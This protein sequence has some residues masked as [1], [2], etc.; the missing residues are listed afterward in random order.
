MERI[1]EQGNS[2]PAALLLEYTQGKLADIDTMVSAAEA[3]AREIPEAP[4][5]ARAVRALAT[6]VAE[7][8]IR[9]RMLEQ[10][11]EDR[12]RERRP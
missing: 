12:D 3:R 1:A 9:L 10:A 7:Q 4:E 8:E 6:H 5:V 11:Q 2:D